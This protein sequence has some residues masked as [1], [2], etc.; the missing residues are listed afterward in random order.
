MYFTHVPDLA[1]H[2]AI[3]S[4]VFLYSFF[5]MLVSFEY[6]L[7]AAGAPLEVRVPPVRN[8]SS[9]ATGLVLMVILKSFTLQCR[10]HYYI[11]VQFVPSIYHASTKNV[12]CVPQSVYIS[13]SA[14][15]SFP[16]NSLKA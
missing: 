12:V 7:V 9:I 13:Y 5:L 10:S 2:S 3:N 1:P 11:L 6:P 8:L 4:L 14:S 15:S 16:Q